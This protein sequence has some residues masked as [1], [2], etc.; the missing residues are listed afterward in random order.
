MSEKIRAGFLGTGMALNM[1]RVEGLGKGGN[2][3]AGIGLNLRRAGASFSGDQ[4]ES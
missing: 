1:G 3:L 4:T 2:A